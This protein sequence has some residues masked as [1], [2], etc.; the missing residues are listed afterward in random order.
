V[1]HLTSALEG[2]GSPIDT[3]LAGEAGRHPGARGYSEPCFPP[4]GTNGEG[5]GN[6]ADRIRTLQLR[7]SRIGQPT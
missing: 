4:Q 6:L 7:A 1:A 5:K 2:P 3:I